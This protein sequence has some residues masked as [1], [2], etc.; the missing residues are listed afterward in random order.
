MRAL[1]TNDDGIES[2]GLHTL[3]MVAAEAGH[4]VL[5]AA[6]SWDSSGASASLT[7]VERDGRLVLESRMLPDVPDAEAYAVEAAP[8]F[9]VR[10]ATTGAFGTPPDLVLSG[11]NQ[12]ANT[13]HAILHS[14]TVGAAF[15]AATFGLPAIAFS[16]SIED[17]PRWD[18][19]AAVVRNVLEWVPHL[20]APTVLNVNIPGVD[21]SEL[22]TL[23][24]APLAPF[25]AVQTTITE[26]GAGY[27]KLGYTEV[28][29][30]PDDDTDAGLL[31]RGIACYSELR[32]V[33][34]VGGH[35]GV[36]CGTIVV[37]GR[38]DRGRAQR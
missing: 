36:P 10:A 3:A 37:S 12:G 21:A 7:A 19:A 29:S 23:C 28:I 31:A 15:T 26:R 2:R 17:E 4:E 32:P 30:D 33:C 6:P 13:G 20:R 35:E 27:V 38:A 1:I 16:L 22:S 34:D 24:R 14:G 18:T 25:G 8:A 9:I 5:V 11:I